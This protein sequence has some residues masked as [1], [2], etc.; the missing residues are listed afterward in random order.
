MAAII[1]A[2]IADS[3]RVGAASRPGSR[4]VKLDVSAIRSLKTEAMADLGS[5][6]EPLYILPRDASLIRLYLRMHFGMRRCPC[7]MRFHGDAP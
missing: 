3:G 2:I 6:A 4:A 5:A 1:E 7:S